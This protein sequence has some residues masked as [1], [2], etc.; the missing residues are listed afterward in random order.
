MTQDFRQQPTFLE[1]QRRRM[2]S[3]RLAAVRMLVPVGFV[4][5]WAV[6]WYLQIVKGPEYH[7]L[8]EEN[9][10]HR[11][12]E[13]ALRGPLV[14]QHGVVMVTNHAGFAVWLA[15]ERTKNGERETRL[16]ARTI[17]EPEEDLV[18]IYQKA[19]RIQARFDPILLLNDVDLE[20]ASRIEANRFDLPSIDVEMTSKRQYP[21]AKA[22]AH[23][24][25]FVSEANED[26]LSA[27][28]DL[29]LGDRVGRTGAERAYDAE[30][31]GVAGIALEEVNASGRPLGVVAI[32]RPPKNGRALITTLDAEM[33]KDLVEAFGDSVGGAV[34]IEPYTGGVRALYSA[35][36]FEPNVF[37]GRLSPAVW[38]SL[39]NDPD[40][41]LLNR[42][43]SS[44]YNPGSTF[45]VVMAAAALEE[46]AT[47][48]GETVGCGGAATF[49]GRVFNCWRKGGHGA[50][51][52][53]EAITQSCNVFFY[54]MGRRL[55]AEK[56]S[57]WAHAFGIG[58]KSGLRFDHEALGLV[59]NDAWSRKVRKQ[60]VYPGEVISMGI[61]QGLVQVSP[62]Q[63]AIVAA[64]I[65][66]GGYRVFPHMVDRPGD[67]PEPRAV[68]LSAETL[69]V[70]TEGMLNVVES[71]RGTASKARVPGYQMA[72][73]TGTAQTISRE[74]EEQQKDNAWFMGF[75]PVGKPELA[76]GII[77][78]RGGHGGATAAPIAGI[79]VKRYLERKEALRNGT[80]PE[81]RREAR[82]AE[83]QGTL[84]AQPPAPPAA[85]PENEGES[86]G[87]DEET[88]V[89]DPNGP[90]QVPNDP[91]DPR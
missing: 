34:F 11:R 19:R 42:V 57:K 87:N 66:N 64:A 20:T 33:Q 91:V 17:G 7:R 8:A 70:I 21:L 49:Y 63:N 80:E 45:K 85:A 15:P 76:W 46:H 60:P 84:Q 13:R 81:Y 83:L 31:R 79:V 48:P 23:A 25:G 4:L 47:S 28:H 1:Y 77:V 36:S 9:R 78:E 59:A 74:A 82:E 39:V 56:I 51:G 71:A 88:T 62:I 37:G 54:T 86:S 68:G 6:F 40:K 73:K 18:R 72:G 55:G 53:Q 52:V 44:A 58:E 65:A 61:G 35:P 41:P 14:D 67:A 24:L 2:R 90:T 69:H 50:I 12:I 22:A 32:Q 29:V 30:L 16:L 27:R 26:D 89:P 38:S 75:G 5:L 3:R 10:L 43:V